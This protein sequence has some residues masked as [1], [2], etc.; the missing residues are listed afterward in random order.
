MRSK[1]SII[2]TGLAATALA[3]VTNTTLTVD[4]YG[5]VSPTNALVTQAQ[6]AAVKAPWR[7]ATS[8]CWPRWKRLKRATTPRLN[9]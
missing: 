7:Q 1:I 8:S 6:I 9:C 3:T 2:A 4:E 5:H